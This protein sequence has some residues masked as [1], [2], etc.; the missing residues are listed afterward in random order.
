VFGVPTATPPAVA[1][2]LA[3]PGARLIIDGEGPFGAR[4]GGHCLFQ[5]GDGSCIDRFPPVAPALSIDGG[6]ALRVLIDQGWRIDRWTADYLRYADGIP[7]DGTVH[8]LDRGRAPDGDGLAE[9]SFTGPPP[10]DW[11][12]DVLLAFHG[13]KATGDVSLQWRLSSL[14]T[15][16]AIVVRGDAGGRAFA[17]AALLGA[18]LVFGAA[19]FVLRGRLRGR[20]SA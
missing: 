3:P 10:G 8:R 7:Q 17:V 20:V 4:R 16:D 12:L 6:D 2:D 5:D 19:W 15:S 13:M 11:R 14:P 9:I 1:A 18:P